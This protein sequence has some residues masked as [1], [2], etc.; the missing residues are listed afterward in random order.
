MRNLCRYCPHTN[1]GALFAV[2]LIFF[3]AIGFSLFILPPSSAAV[4]ILVNYLQL[5][6]V[7]L[8][9]MSVQAADRNEKFSGWLFAVVDLS[10]WDICI[11][12][13]NF[14]AAFWS[15]WL[16]FPVLLAVLVGIWY[17]LERW[18]PDVRNRSWMK[19]FTRYLQSASRTERYG[20]VFWM[21]L[22]LLQ[23]PFIYVTLRML[24]CI[25]SSPLDGDFVLQNDPSITCSGSLYRFHQAIS[26]IFCILWIY[27]L[28]VY[29][30][31]FTR[32]LWK[33]DPS[34]WLREASWALFRP[35]QTTFVSVDYLFQLRRLLFW[36]M[37][38]L[39]QS[40]LRTY[41]GSL[42]LVGFVGVNVSIAPFVHRL[43]NLAELIAMG[44]SVITCMLLSSKSMTMQKAREVSQ[45]F[46]ITYYVVLV[47]VTGLLAF[48]FWY[49]RRLL[50]ADARSTVANL[51]GSSVEKNSL[52]LHELD[53]DPDDEKRSLASAQSIDI[54]PSEPPSKA[55][56]DVKQAM[57]PTTPRKLASFDAMGSSLEFPL[58]GPNAPES[59]A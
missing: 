6:D 16:L 8:R 56:G 13:M 5:G 2:F 20:S 1:G 57:D 36:T 42:V 52:Q 41:A 19:R 45:A 23:A 21:L 18:G 48:S 43:D 55:N 29:S 4:F 46:N 17:A 39:V 28:P 59:R 44:L 9:E 27:P 33:V 12:P 32:Y 37:I 22:N 34:H 3:I 10:V 54:S 25:E 11:V 31:V 15:T 26:I 40:D 49:H 50:E 35:Y 38:C 51:N 7:L 30:Y 24:T 47:L 53:R 14:Y 58:F